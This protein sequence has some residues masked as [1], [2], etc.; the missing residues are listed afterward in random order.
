MFDF[1]GAGMNFRK[2]LMEYVGKDIYIGIEEKDGCRTEHV[3]H[4]YRLTQCSGQNGDFCRVV[5]ENPAAASVELDISAEVT[6]YH[7]GILLVDVEAMSRSLNY[8]IFIADEIEW[9]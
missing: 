6:G 2:I 5:P 8:H 9:I 1:E 3:I 4:G 7:Q